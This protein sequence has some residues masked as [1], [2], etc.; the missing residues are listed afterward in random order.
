MSFSSLAMSDGVVGGTGVEDWPALLRFLLPCPELLIVSDPGLLGG[1]SLTVGP[2][3]G[4]EV[5]I[6]LDAKPAAVMLL[7]CPLPTVGPCIIDATGATVTGGGGV[8][9]FPLATPRFDVVTT[10][11]LLEDKLV[12]T[13][14]TGNGT[15]WPCW[16][17][18]VLPRFVFRV[19]SCLSVD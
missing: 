8:W 11:V 18:A 2:M 17:F 14:D 3:A 7:K 13:D 16:L 6:A 5:G 15:C 4:A 12:T 19:F 9:W 10:L 1:D